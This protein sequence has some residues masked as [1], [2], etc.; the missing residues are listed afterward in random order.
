MYWQVRLVLLLFTIHCSLSTSY[1]Q[2]KHPWEEALNEVMTL[3]DAGTTAWEETYELLCDL[4]LHP[5]NLNSVTREQLEQLPFLTAQQVEDIMA[6]LYQYGPMKSEAELMMIRSLD[7]E[8][9]RLLTYFIYIGE[10]ADSRQQLFKYGHHELMAAA[11]IPFYERKGDSNGYLG[12]PYRHW[13]RYQL[14]Y[15]DRVKVGLVGSQDAGEP[16][17]ANCNKTGYDYYS[18]YLQLRNIGWL[19]SLVLGRYKVSLGMGLTINSSFSLGKVAM[20]QNLGR[21]A[22]T[23]RAHSSRSEADYLQGAAATFRLSKA[24]SLTAFASYRGQDATLNKDGTAAT[25]VTSGYHRTETEMEKK[26]NLKNA[27]VGGSLRYQRY[28]LH[29]GL[30]TVYTHL[31]RRLTPNT[32]TLYRR[33][34][35]Q[36]NDFTNVSID[37]GYVHHR[38]AVQGETAVNAHGALATINSVS[39]QLRDGLSLMAL[40]R[41]YSYRYTA[42][43]ARSFSDGSSVQNE[44]GLYVGLAW[45]PSPYLKLMA[46]GD[47]AYFPWAKYQV[48]QSS[49]AQDYLLQATYTHSHWTWGGRY[50]LRLRE[51]DNAEKTAL[52]SRTEH[53][54]RVSVAYDNGWSS[55][56][57][58]DVGFT[59]VEQEEKG[60]MVS[61]T[62]GYAWRW[63][64][65]NGGFGY[66]KTDGYDS[67]VY[68]YE[69]GPLYTYSMGQFQGEG[70]R[71]W[72]MARAAIG[73]NL[74]LTAKWGR[75]KYTDRE[76]VGSG[77]Q[78][79]DGSA[80]SDLDVQLRWKF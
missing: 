8:R 7:R 76:I 73:R 47:Y 2:D 61:E 65:L 40:Q 15:G 23:L 64:R 75:T 67:R 22:N 18:L 29:V 3:E 17:F 25:I 46:Y 54:G 56:T 32:S 30:N 52:V 77:Y 53:R 24:L 31:D 42:L 26:H 38:F 69:S 58:L 34:Y 41:F 49:Y 11:R 62:L 19:E 51:R 1:A 59:A 74:S 66:F 63:L 78:Q 70:W 39:L 36:G 14:T 33:H 4:E 50:R 12:Y 43:Y 72:L 48:S 6:Y 79:V 55:K 27:T 35:A 20:L 5:M 16:F 13:L 44:S 57:Q 10:S 37:Y 60:L 45:Q 9:R 68:L 21:A 71:C 80:L 28:G